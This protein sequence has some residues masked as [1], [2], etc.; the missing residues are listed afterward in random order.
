L[1]T[2]LENIEPKDEPKKATKKSKKKSTSEKKTIVKSLNGGLLTRDFFIKNLNYLVFVTGILVLYIGY[3]YYVDRISRDIID[4]E[5]KC[6]LLES[7]L[8]SEKSFYNQ[9]KMFYKISDSLI[10]NG[11][12]HKAPKKIKVAANKFKVI[13]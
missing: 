9:Q 6:R 12:V 7:E 5:D 10:V 2:L 13:E 1:S 4:L 8:A 11:Y 3:G